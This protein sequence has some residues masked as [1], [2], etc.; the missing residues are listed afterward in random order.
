MTF[1]EKL[2]TIERLHQLIHMQATGKPN[3]LANKLGLSRRAVFDIINLIKQLGAPVEYCIYK[4]TYYY[5]FECEL[6]IRYMNRDSHG[7]NEGVEKI[8]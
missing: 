7:E 3:V 5:T 8:L 2:N 1:L 6:N 4:Q